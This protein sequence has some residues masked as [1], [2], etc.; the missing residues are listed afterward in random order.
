[1]G[2]APYHNLIV[3]DQK[4]NEFKPDGSPRDIHVLGANHE[5]W[6]T[7]RVAAKRFNRS[8]LH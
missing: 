4:S 5:T 3:W 6:E 7:L 1:M 8:A 2:S